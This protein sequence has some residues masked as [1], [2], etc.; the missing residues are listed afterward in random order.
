MK[1]ICLHSDAVLGEN[2]KLGSIIGHKS[3]ELLLIS[4]PL[5]TVQTVILHVKLALQHRLL[6]NIIIII[7]IIIIVIIIIIIIIIIILPLQPACDLER[8]ALAV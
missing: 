8:S 2:L 5:D 1:F 4:V 7:I 6:D 3:V